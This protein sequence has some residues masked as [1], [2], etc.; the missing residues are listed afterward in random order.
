MLESFSIERE[1]GLGLTVSVFWEFL[2]SFAGWASVDCESVLT[3]TGAI[4]MS[5]LSDFTKQ[6]A[7]GS[8]CWGLLR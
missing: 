8:G 1:T 6:K 7:P 5:G 4:L 2:V 3:V